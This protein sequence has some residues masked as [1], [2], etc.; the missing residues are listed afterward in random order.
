MN[1]SN[2]IEPAMST[3]MPGTEINPATTPG[4][5]VPAVDPSPGTFDAD[6][7]PSDLQTCEV[8]MAKGLQAFVAAGLA[9]AGIRD[10]RL[11]RGNFPTFDAYCRQKWHRGARSVNR[12]ISAAQL[13]TQLAAT[14][15]QHKPDR[16]IQIRSLVGLTA[17][18]TKPERVEFV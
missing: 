1:K 5:A 18:V 7:E 16:Q 3:T 12:L 13:F 17:Q 10:Q 15:L 6:G 4:A 8:I 14:C 9:F 11:Y 2:K